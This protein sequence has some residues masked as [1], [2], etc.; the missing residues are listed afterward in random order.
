MAEVILCR[1]RTSKPLGLISAGLDVMV[2]VPWR[3]AYLVDRWSANP[4]D[5]LIELSLRRIPSGTIGT[6]S[7][8]FPQRPDG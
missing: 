4:D 7:R 5:L 8:N 1:R 2:K 3:I 6:S